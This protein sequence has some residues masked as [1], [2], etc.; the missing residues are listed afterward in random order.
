MSNTPLNERLHGRSYI[1]LHPDMTEAAMSSRNAAPMVEDPACLSENS[2]TERNIALV[3]FLVS[4]AYLYLFRRFTGMEPDEGIILQGAERVL[5][6][7]TPYRDFFSF[8]TP[9]SYYMTAAALKLLGDSLAAARSV[10]ALGASVVSALTYLLARR[11]CSRGVALL[12]AALTTCTC[13]PYRDLVLHNWDS[14]LWAMLAL[15]AAVLYLEAP[16]AKRAF[17]LGSLAA[18]TVLVEQSKG[19]GLTLG[20]ALG[21]AVLAIASWRR[22]RLCRL[23]CGKPPAFREKSGKTIAERKGVAAGAES[24]RLSARQAAKP[25]A[26]IAAGFM[27]PFA[28]VFAWF[29]HQHAVAPMVADWLWPLHHYSLANSVGYGYQNWSDAS[30]ATLFGD[31]SWGRRLLFLAVATPCFLMPVL[32]LVAAAVFAWLSYR[33]IWG[34]R[35]VGPDRRRDAALE[36]GRDGR[37][38]RKQ[39]DPWSQSPGLYRDAG[40][41]RAQYY[42]LASAVITGLLLS[43]LAGRTDILHFVYLAPMLYLVLAWILNGRD[44]P[45]PLFRALRP[46]L[47]VVVVTCF[48]LLAAVL[49]VTALTAPVSIKTRRGEVRAPAPDQVLAAIQ[50]Q[51]DSGATIF[52]YPYL[53]LYYY[54]TATFAPGP[55]DYL[56]PGM[57]TPEQQAEMVRHVADDRTPVVVYEYAFDDK[58]ASSWPRT[59]IEAI[60]KDPVADF[61]LAHYRS[62]SVLKSAAGGRFL[63]MVRKD[64]GCPGEP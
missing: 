25:L 42:L 14:T 64:L 20:L 62:C 22:E 41:T 49:A 5:H 48:A 33:A 37:A 60:A 29:A 13:L 17:A 26:A 56:Q 54:L 44:V 47:R 40:A 9:G 35:G 32:P 15:Y 23:P 45:S 11:V 55:H 12:A 7:Q 6:G 10:V 19:A 51:V 28:V 61:L 36:S 1:R 58:I 30:R 46:V 39:P 2:T 63:F 3:V 24:R 21:F 53:P 59:P 43:V 34:G 57:H 31:A 4:F 50:S 8:Y 27:W 16:G 52:V 38:V 18:V